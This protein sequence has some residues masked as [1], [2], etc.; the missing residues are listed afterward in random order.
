MHLKKRQMIALKNLFIY[1]TKQL[2]DR[3]RLPTSFVNVGKYVIYAIFVSNLKQKV[4]YNIGIVFH[5]VSLE[6]S[7]DTDKK[8]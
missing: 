7:T 2:V 1:A 6:F 3:I 8:L 4:E 5:T